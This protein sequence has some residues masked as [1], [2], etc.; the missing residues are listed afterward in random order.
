MRNFLVPPIL[1]MA[2]VSL[3]FSQTPGVET[4]PRVNLLVG[5]WKANLSKSQ[6]DPN[7][8]FQ[9]LALRIESS[10]DGVLLLTFTGISMSGKEESVK[11]KL[12]PDGKEYPVAEANGIVQVSRWVGPQTLES[13]A[14]KDGTVIGESRYEVSSD[15]KTLTSKVKGTDAKGRQFEQLIVF[16]RD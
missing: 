12:Q 5:N 15:G 11:Q 4:K 10:D 3:A 9:S 7:H 13:V 2:I 1:L 8:Q 6:R 14:R 16:D